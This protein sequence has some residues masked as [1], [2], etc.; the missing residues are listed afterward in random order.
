MALHL[1]VQTYGWY[2]YQQEHESTFSYR[3]VLAECAKTGFRGVD[4]TGAYLP[5]MQDAAVV[6]EVCDG[7]GVRIVCTGVGVDD[8]EKARVA[9]EFL[10]AQAGTALMAGGGWVPEGEDPEQVMDKLIQDA[11]AMA[12]LSRELDFPIGFHNHLGTV[13]ET[14]EGLAR[15]LDSTE[16]GWCADLG[17]MASGG[18]KPLEFLERYGK[19]VVHCHLKDS[20]LDEQ[21]QHVRFCE[22]GKGT[23]G[24]DLDACLKVLVAQG[25]DGWACVEQDQTTL[26]PF[27]DQKYNHDYLEGLGYGW[28]LED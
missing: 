28:A 14:P 7:L 11:N 20:M 10:R 6:R 8:L 18:A 21:G 17:H 5:Q 9:I 16:I 1:G 27:A 13:T 3:L 25:F 15:F 19:R 2:A 22:L 26:T 12:E 24:I 4:M 23:A